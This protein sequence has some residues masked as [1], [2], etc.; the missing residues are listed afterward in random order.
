MAYDISIAGAFSGRP[1][2]QL[3]LY[4][5][6]DQT[7]IP[8][9]RS[10]YAWQL[11][12]E[13]VS[14]G[15]TF[16]LNPQPWSVNVAGF[17]VN[18]ST[19]L[20]FRYTNSI[21]MGASSTGWVAHD[22]NGYLNIYVGASIN[23]SGELFG[24]ANAAATFVTDR[25]PKPPGPTNPVGI[26]QIGPTSMVY[27]FNGGSD[28]GSA[29]TSWQIQY[30]TNAGFTTGVV[31]ITSP[32]TSTLTPLTPGTQYW[33]RSRGNNA[34]GSGPWS[35]ASTAQTLSGAFVG[36]LANATFAAAAVYVGKSGAY[37][38]AEVRVGKDGN[39]VIAS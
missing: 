34:V 37:V 26:S 24:V 20:D 12:A 6:R 14:S 25:I 11:L 16:A 30:A 4:V 23:A 15:T 38:V 18:G 27:A 35:G 31:T 8:N 29:I 2:Y 32:G 19:P 5:R 7:D 22:A 13:K 3:R 17:V 36:K 10:S 1:A 21:S 33:V 39:Y 9:N 28:G